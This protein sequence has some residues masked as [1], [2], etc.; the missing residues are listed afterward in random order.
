MLQAL[1]ILVRRPEGKTWVYV[2][3]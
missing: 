2:G 3:R 1:K